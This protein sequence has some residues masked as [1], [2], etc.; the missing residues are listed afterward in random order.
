MK[1]FIPRNWFIKSNATGD[2]N[3]DGIADLAMIIEYKDTIEEIRQKNQDSFVNK[4]SP[5]I[6]LVL[7]KN[8]FSGFYHL[9]LQNNTFILRYGEGG[10][11]PEPDGEVLISKR[12][13]S[14]R[15][16]F[17]R[18]TD[19]YKFRYQNGDFYLIGFSSF[20][21][22]G[23]TL[24]GLEINFITMKIKKSTGDISSDHDKITWQRFSYPH[25]IKLKDYA[26]RDSFEITPDISL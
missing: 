20:G 5:R 7:F 4:G 8:K 2:L 13:L 1:S 15:Y 26:F 25:L 6:L 19:I 10:M 9:I 11:D 18:D 16:S 23:S 22:S 21:V 24:D 14:I 3:G 12:V 17:L